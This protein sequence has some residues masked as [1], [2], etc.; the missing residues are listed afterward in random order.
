MQPIIH[1]LFT[2][3]FLWCLPAVSRRET[4][5]FSDRSGLNLWQDISLPSWSPHLDSPPETLCVQRGVV[6]LCSLRAAAQRRIDLSCQEHGPVQATPC[7]TE[8]EMRR[9]REEVNVFGSDNK[10]DQDKRGA[11]RKQISSSRKK[12]RN[13]G[14]IWIRGNLFSGVAMVLKPN[15]EYMTFS[16]SLPS[17]NYK[18]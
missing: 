9:Q 7:V 17:A 12:M 8:E 15:V 18:E 16:Q 1:V 11:T 4:L 3:S 2:Y 14:L 10:A 13:E 5:C 6:I